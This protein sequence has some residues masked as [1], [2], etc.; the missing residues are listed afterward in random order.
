MNLYLRLFLLLLRLIGLPRRGLLEESRVAFRVLPTD[1]DINIHMNNGR[2]L[3]FMDLGRVHLMAQLGLIGPIFRRRWKPV[4]AAADINFIRPLAPFQ[5]FDLVSR[6][7]TWDDKYAYME[8]RFES[9][10]T[11]CAHA[12]VKGLFLGER[13]RVANSSVVAE[14]GYDGAPPP[15]P[16]ELKAWVELGDLKRQ[17]A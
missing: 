9:S 2:Y 10:G 4:L 3:T 5:K 12:W 13:G 6:I 8:Q 1:C 7:V 17:K 16:E 15:C 11:L 14:I